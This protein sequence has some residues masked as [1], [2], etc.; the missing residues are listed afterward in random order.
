[1]LFVLRQIRRKAM[2][3][4]KFTTYLLYAIGE[5][6][7]VVLG[8]LI[9]VRIDDWNE[10]KRLQKQQLKYYED[11]LVD[12]KKDSL[13]LRRVDAALKRY[14]T[15]FYAIFDESQGVFGS[16]APKY[17]YLLHNIQFATSMVKNQ[18]QTIDK[19]VNSEIRQLINGYAQDQAGVETAIGEYNMGVVQMMR[20]FTIGKQVWNPKVIFKADMFTFLPKESILDVEKMR[21]LLSDQEM[22]H[23]LSYLR[24]STAFGIHEVGELIDTNQQLIGVLRSELK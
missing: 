20:P 14:Q 1:M 5:I 2:A 22:I 23:K 19:L 7:L 3:E 18:Q 8:I 12:L 9:A 13:E 24:M 21:A 15:T 17:D 16:K 10:E 11:I 4:S 6:V